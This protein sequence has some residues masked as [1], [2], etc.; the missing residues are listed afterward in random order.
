MP[1]VYAPVSGKQGP[2]LTYYQVFV[3]KDAP[4]DGMVSPRFP[5]GFADGTA[6]TF[7][8]AEAGEAVPWTKP[9]DLPYDAARPLPKLGGLFAEGLHVAMADGT[10]RFVRR[11]ATEKAIRA[12]I[13][14]RNGED[15]EP[16][17]KPVK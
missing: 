14:P 12:A 3:G 1:K 16:P 5:A 2:G 11:G 13:T 10:V 8:V 4:F 17:G 7:L 9:T 15:I 6:N